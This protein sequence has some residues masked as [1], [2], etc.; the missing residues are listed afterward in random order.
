M[1]RVVVLDRTPARRSPRTSATTTRPR[2]TSPATT[3]TASRRSP[4]RSSLPRHRGVRPGRPRRARHPL[5]RPAR[6]HLWS[7]ASPILSERDL[8]R[9]VLITGAGGQLGRALAEAFAGDDV[10]A[11]TR[12]DWDVSLPPPPLVPR[13]T[14]VL[15]AA[16][17]TDVDGAEDD[18]QGAAAVNVGGTAHAAALGAPLVAF[19]TDY[20]FDG[21]KREPYLESDG[22]NPLSAYGRTKLHGEAAA[23]ERAWIVRTSWLFG[24]TGHNFVR[25]MLRLGAERDEVAVVDDQRG[26][27]T[28]V[29]HLAAATRELVALPYGVYHVA[30]E[31]DC[32]WADFAEAIFE[33]AGLDCRVRRITTAEFGRP[34]PRPA[35]SVLRSEQG[36]PRAAALARRAARVPRAGWRARIAG[37]RATRFLTTWVARRAASTTVWEAIHDDERW[38]EWWRGVEGR[39][40]ARA[41]TTATASARVH[42]YVW[43]SRLPYDIEFEIRTTR[44]ERPP[45]RGR[46]R[47]GELAATGR[48]RLWDGRGTVVTYEWNVD[49]DDRVDERAR[50][51]SA[52]PVFDWSHDAVM[53]NGGRGPGRAAGGDAPR[54]D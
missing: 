24:P 21:R 46:R 44:V 35:Y 32:T 12:A 11:L 13:R 3:R 34:A 4:T 41:A 29:G 8:A 54:R 19:S 6:Q 7:T 5:G 33:E 51:R 18:P 45:A 22:P 48:W 52:R 16:A 15:H 42:R 10:V 47:T 9:V 49:D 39:R 14:L 36:A 20:V 38:P 50:A 1:V 43:R 17:W 27:P 31:G 2:S 30:A 53:R 40:G 37:W 23:G 25:T 28:Y 26:C